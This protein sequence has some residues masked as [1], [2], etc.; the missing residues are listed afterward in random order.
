LAERFDR[1]DEACDVIIGLLSDTTTNFA[2]RHY[3]LHGARCE[4][5]PVQRPHPPICIGGT[6]ERRTLRTVARCAQHWNYPGGSVE[7]WAHKREVLREHCAAIGRDP[8]TITT[9]THLRL[10]PDGDVGPLV[11][12]ASAYAE[13]GL[14]LGIVQLVPPHRPQ[15]L[16]KA[17]AALEPLS[18]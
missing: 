16:E 4:P 12:Q 6:G 13:A 11:E 15:V 7:Q 9:S 2:G 17:A 1:F 10:L 3:Q 14:D 18:A 5:T 8:S